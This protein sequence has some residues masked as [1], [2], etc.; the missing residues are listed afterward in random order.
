MDCFQVYEQNNTK[1][2][3][4]RK[5]TCTGFYKF[6]LGYIRVQ[7]ESN[8]Y[9]AGVVILGFDAQFALCAQ[10]GPCGSLA[11]ACVGCYANKGLFA[12]LIDRDQTNFNR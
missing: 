12:Q 11:L 6:S 3:L 5:K 9:I 2:Y 7:I 1:I 10:V 4:T 8:R